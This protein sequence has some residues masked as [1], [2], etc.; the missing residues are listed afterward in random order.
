MNWFAKPDDIPFNHEIG[1]RNSKQVYD[2]ILSHVPN[3]GDT[4][5]IR[6]ADPYKARNIEHFLKN[7]K[8]KPISVKTKNEYMNFQFI[9]TRTKE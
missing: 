6:T 5:T 3:V 2:E 9:I 7:W 8:R 1:E 4:G